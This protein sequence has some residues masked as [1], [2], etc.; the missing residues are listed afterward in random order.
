MFQL[1]KLIT[2]LKNTPVFNIIVMLILLTYPALLLTVRS[3]MGVLLGVLL[4]ISM[5]QLFRIRKRLS[6][7]HWDKYSIAFSITMASPVMA[8]FL[9]QAYHGQFNAPSYD[10]AS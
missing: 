3:G 10:W 8:I 5:V 6:I 1:K 7:P 2:S 4:I 9:S